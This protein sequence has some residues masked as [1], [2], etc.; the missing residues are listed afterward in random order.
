MSQGY[1]C[2][3]CGRSD[4]EVEIVAGPAVYICEECIQLC[5]EILKERSLERIKE[6]IWVKCSGNTCYFD[7]KTGKCSPGPGDDCSNC[8]FKHRMVK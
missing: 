8:A 4:E 7:P 3:F 6:A 5:S 1:L 2:S